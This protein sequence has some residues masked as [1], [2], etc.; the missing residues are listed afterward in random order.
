MVENQ[1]SWL[2]HLTE[3]IVSDARGP[4]LDAYAIALE[5]WRRGLTLRWH[6]K[7]SEKFSE[8]DTWF[9]DRPGKLFSL[10]SED[11]THY[12]FR[13]RGDKVTNEAVRIGGDKEK[14]KSLLTKAGVCTP[15]SKQFKLS[16]ENYDHILQYAAS[17]GY[18]LVIKPVNGS[19][20]KGVFTDIKDEI[21]LAK[22]MNYLNGKYESEDV[23]VEKH[24]EGTD[25][26]LYVI[27]DKVVGAIKRIPANIVGDGVHSIKDLIYEKNQERKKNPRLISC[28]IKINDDI[29]SFLQKKSLDLF[30]VPKQG[31]VVFLTDKS[32]ISIGGDP[33]DSLDDLPYSIKKLGVEAIK[34]IPG[35]YHGAVDVIVEGEGDNCIGYVLE[36]NPS[37]QIG[38]IL[39]PEEGEARDV[40]GAII[41]YYF[42]ETINTST[43]YKKVFF[44]LSDVLEPL[45]TKTATVTTVSPAPVGKIYATKY[46]LMGDVQNVAYHRG[47]RK[48]AFERRHSGYIKNLSNGNIEVVVMGT[49]DD[50][51]N[52]FHEALISDTERADV[53][54]IIQEKWNGPVKVGFEVKADLKTQI[55]QFKFLKKQMELVRS[56][57]KIVEKQNRAIEKSITWRMTFPIRKISDLLKIIGRKMNN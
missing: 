3:E 4:E 52:N 17:I 11:K 42:P 1:V 53:R 56:D 39:F 57:L 13:T 30:T 18:P 5:G 40:P 21:E 31:E 44:S 47:I 20:G 12:F 45:I 41:D 24:V 54:D 27:E 28:P 26:R 29:K 22:T 32:N 50:T 43:D 34:S 16:T 38:S 49:C 6:A 2:P 19:F 51:V 10:S 46:T 36:L 7:D 37:A 25:Y 15:I 9:V 14:T 55:E 23:L 33:I 35:L 8:M 48:Q